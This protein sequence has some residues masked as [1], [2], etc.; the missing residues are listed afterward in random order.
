LKNLQKPEKNYFSL[1]LI[2]SDSDEYSNIEYGLFVLN[3]FENVTL[4]NIFMYAEYT[5]LNYVLSV[6]ETI[7]FSITCFESQFQFLNLNKLKF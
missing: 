3:E 4:F 6:F 1:N 7:S 5:M 2:K